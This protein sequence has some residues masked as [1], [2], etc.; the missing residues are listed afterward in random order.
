MKKF[1]LASVL[2]IL[3][4][5]FILCMIFTTSVFVQDNS[6]KTGEKIVDSFVQ[7]IGITTKKKNTEEYM[8]F[9]L[10]IMMG[11]YPELTRIGSKYVSNQSDLDL[12]L[13]YATEQTSPL[14]KDF[15]IEAE[16]KEVIPP[17]R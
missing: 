16:E 12:I 8:Q 17:V 10:G 14:F 13:K 9:M 7:E 6:E 3:C 5:I 1:K 15:P 11:E 2:V 4:I